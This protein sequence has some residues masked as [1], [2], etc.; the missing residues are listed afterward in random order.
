MKKNTASQKIG[1]Q[2]V[3]A[4]DGSAFTSAV[5]VYVTGDAGT[6]AV[7]SVSSGACTHEGNGYHTYAPAQAETN[8]DLI[9][10]T[11]IGTGAVPA[12]VQVETSHDANLIQILGTAAST[13]ATAGILDVNVKNIDNDAASAS[14]TVTFPNSTL[15]STTNITAGT[16]TTVGAVTGLTAATVHSDLDDIQS[17]LPAALGANGNIKA[18]I[19]DL[20]GTAWLTPGTAG[21]PDVNTKLVGGTAVA[22]IAG[23]GKT[24]YVAT[25]GNDSNAGTAASPKLTINGAIAAMTDFDR[26]VIGAGAFNATVTCGLNHV[27]FEGQG[28][29]QTTITVSSGTAWTITGDYNTVRNMSMTTSH[30]A[31]QR[32][33]IDCNSTWG[34]HLENLG[35]AGTY[36]GVYGGGTINLT[37]KGCNITGDYDGLNVS[38]AW[39]F[40]VNDTLCYTTGN[41]DLYFDL[42][43]VTPEAD[44][45]RGVFCG[46]ETR[47]VFNRCKFRAYQQYAST[48]PV[49]AALVGGDDQGTTGCSVQFNNCTFQVVSSHA[50]S[51]GMAACLSN[52]ATLS[53]AYLAEVRG[54]R[55]T[56]SN[57]GSG[58]SYHV[59][60]PV[61]G[62]RVILSNVMLHTTL[63]VDTPGNV[64][65]DL[66]PTVA[67]RS[68]D[69][70]AT[71]EVGVDW[72]NVGSPTTTVA[73][74]NTTISSSSNPSAATIA[75]AVWD[76]VRSPDHTT[77]GTF[78]KYLDDQVSSVSGGTISPVN[79]DKKHTW[80]FKS[81]NT[82]TAPE[83]LKEFI[84]FGG[85]VAMDF[86]GRMPPRSSISSISSAIFTNIA[87]TEP[88]VSNSAVSADKTQAHVTID[89]SAAT[90]GTYTLNVTIVTTDS[91]TFV[92]KG[93]IIIE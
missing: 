90:A 50:S 24:I 86:S 72:A 29:G 7:G 22:Q 91:Q 62:S 32:W 60:A 2:M 40:E 11:F 55:M 31:N 47:G 64:I 45:Y 82:T 81:T 42:S 73:L 49:I 16:I 18:D 57:S 84:P 68:A 15:A 74:T 79:V 20:L 85:I 83:I 76:E 34:T 71:G 36:D 51:T 23:L 70:S 14:G 21:T 88:T 93:R 27:T 59:N 92:G 38:S 78:G 75:D 6:Q 56:Y 77:A 8:Y 25:T 54:G 17:R 48:K 10:F 65:T 67:G 19:R 46:L 80:T 30:V 28:Q 52:D 37:I 1:C 58:S 89:S 33:A 66:R 53:L 35:L 4:T 63:S 12:T 13:P 26:C 5:T 43:L 3:S 87:G 61:S 69:V 41:W 44:G 9:A 39:G